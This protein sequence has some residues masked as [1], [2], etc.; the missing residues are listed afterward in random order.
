MAKRKGVLMNKTKVQAMVRIASASAFICI[1]SLISIPFAVPLTMQTFAIF[2]VLFR[3]GGREGLSAVLVY[4]ALG[5]LG[6]PVFSGAMGG[7]GR[8]FDL[9]GGYIFGF[10]CAAVIY[11]PLSKIQM[12]RPIVRLLTAAVPPMLLIYLMGA[13]WY[14][15]LTEVGIFRAFCICVLPFIIPD[16]VK[17]FLAYDIS[18]RLKKRGQNP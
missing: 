18:Q 9:G 1:C 13:L 10:A 11:I 16:A 14:S 8:L 4:I 3:L 7:I 5:A 12:R 6:L 2:F 15:A 17:I